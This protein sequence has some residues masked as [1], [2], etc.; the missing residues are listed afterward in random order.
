M[1]EVLVVFGKSSHLLDLSNSLPGKSFS[2]MEAVWAGQAVSVVIFWQ[3]IG[4]VQVGSKQK[5][6]RKHEV[7]LLM[8][9]R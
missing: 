6:I 3:Q 5:Q 1:S 4:L 8:T 2:T 9:Q 7:I